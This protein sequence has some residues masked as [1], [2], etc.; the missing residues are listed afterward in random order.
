V[1]GDPTPRPADQPSEVENC[2]TTE[3]R[4]LIDVSDATS[5]GSA[6][7]A[8]LDAVRCELTATPTT[9]CTTDAGSFGYGSNVRR[10]GA[11]PQSVYPTAT[12]SLAS[13]ETVDF[14]HVAV[15]PDIGA[16]ASAFEFVITYTGVE[17][18]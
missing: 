15:A 7:T 17:G 5:V 3:L 8:A 13:G 10:A 16:P 18:G 2:A 14:D 4:V 6:G 12:V 9:T 1:S 11:P